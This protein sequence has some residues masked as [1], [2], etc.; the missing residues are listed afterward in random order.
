MATSRADTWLLVRR[1]T[2]AL[3]RISA[4]LLNGG[5]WS[6]QD[7]YTHQLPDP[8]L[9][10]YGSGSKTAFDAAVATA[11]EIPGTETNLR[12]GVEQGVRS[13]RSK[14]DLCMTSSSEQKHT[15]SKASSIRPASQCGLPRQ[16]WSRLSEGDP[17]WSPTPCVK[18]QLCN[19]SMGRHLTTP[20]LG[21]TWS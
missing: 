20:R 15:P 3:P 6:L 7:Y 5:V 13:D 9:E 11:L 21:Q 17:S 4:S 10:V 18:G 12:W 8:I 14:F 19:T 16:S 2:A 1:R